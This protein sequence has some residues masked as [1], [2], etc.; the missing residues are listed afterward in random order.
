MAELAIGMAA[1]VYR[2]TQRHIDR[3]VSTSMTHSE[4]DHRGTE[5]FRKL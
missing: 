4:E 5:R 1:E 3:V 2:G